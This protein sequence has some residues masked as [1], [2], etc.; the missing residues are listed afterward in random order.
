MAYA[1]RKQCISL[2]ARLHRA[3]YVHNSLYTRNI[4]MQP[5]PLTR[6]PSLRSIDTP[7]FRLIDL[8]RA[9][10]YDGYRCRKTAARVDEEEINQQWQRN[11]A[12]ELRE[13]KELFTEV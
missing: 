10:R 2:V 12:N 3:G 13:A 7:S 1:D 5:G 9:E 8:G 6:P 4:L 11:M